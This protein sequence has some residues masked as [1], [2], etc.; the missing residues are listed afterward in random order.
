M[1]LANVTVL[2]RSRYTPR[3]AQEKHLGR[4]YL[5]ISGVERVDGYVTETRRINSRAAWVNVIY[6]L[7][8]AAGG[9][10]KLHA[11]LLQN[12]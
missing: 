3:F 9:H 8:A 11:F 7:S 2:C 1:E 5:Q 4:D 6:V 10:I 12:M